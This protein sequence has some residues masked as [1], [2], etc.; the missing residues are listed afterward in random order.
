[1]FQCLR[2]RLNHLIVGMSITGLPIVSLWRAEG[3]IPTTKNKEGRYQPM[4]SQI[5]GKAFVITSA[6]STKDIK[7]AGNICP[8]A[9]KIVDPETKNVLF[10]V[11][12][13]DKN[14][15]IGKS[16]VIFDSSDRAGKAQ[17]TVMLDNEL[18]R[19]Q[20]ADRYGVALMSL[21]TVEAQFATEFKAASDKL[22]A[23]IDTEEGVAAE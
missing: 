11:S 17:I 21:N 16:G 20:L 23:A 5:A 13:A 9:L 3:V 15:D 19:E 2:L 14:G 4:K 10:Q 6:M 12:V 8:N 22:D 18:S 1:M 7:R